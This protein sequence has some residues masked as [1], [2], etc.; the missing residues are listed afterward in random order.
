MLPFENR[1]IVYRVSQ[2]GHHRDVR[3][4]GTAAPALAAECVDRPGVPTTN[5]AGN[6]AK[7]DFDYRDEAGLDRFAMRIAR[8]KT[9]PGEPGPDDSAVLRDDIA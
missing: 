4:G 9:R 5:F 2:S 7:I 3:L 6:E 1:W 8:Q